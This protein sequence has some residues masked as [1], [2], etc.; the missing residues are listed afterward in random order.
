MSAKIT[1]LLDLKKE[2]QKNF[3]DLEINFLPSERRPEW[4]EVGKDAK[5]E[6]TIH[7]NLHSDCISVFGI[8]RGRSDSYTPRPLPAAAQDCLKQIE[9]LL[10]PSIPVFVHGPATFGWFEP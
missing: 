2:L 6:T 5:G 8:V 7:V 1:S 9:T 4:I 10:K 3:A